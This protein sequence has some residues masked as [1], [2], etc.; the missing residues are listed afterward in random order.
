MTDRKTWEN[1]HAKAGSIAAPSPL[2]ERHAR[3]VADTLPG[4]RA[5]DLACGTGRHAALLSRLGFLTF[6]VDFSVQALTRVRA[7]R[8]RIVRV[9]ADAMH[10][11]LAPGCFD[12]IVQTCFLERDLFPT[13]AHLLRPG[14]FLIAE[15]FSV[16]QSETTGHPRREF[17]LRPGE[18]RDL[19]ERDGVGLKTIE[20]AQQTEAPD[21]TPRFLDAIVARRP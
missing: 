17:C 8:S 18:L 2:V 12:L 21:G 3:H 13:L 6:A 11:P 16:A 5:L 14:G 20:T 15:T 9:A 7:S 1:R 4:A 10:L 19:C